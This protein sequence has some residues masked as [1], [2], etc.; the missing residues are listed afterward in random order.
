[1]ENGPP[2]K[3]NPSRAGSRAFCGQRRLNA[4]V[5]QPAHSA[6]F[7]YPS[8][9]V[10]HEETPQ[11]PIRLL[12]GAEGKAPRQ[13]SRLCLV[14]RCGQAIMAS[15]LSLVELFRPAGTIQAR[16]FALPMTLDGWQPI[17][18]APKDGSGVILFEPY[19]GVAC[20]GYW[21]KEDNEWFPSR[22]KQFWKQPTHWQPMPVYVYGEQ[23]R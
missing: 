9:L 20:S 23:E 15:G 3:Q 10:E 22:G 11:T 21:S 18:T 17:E 6:K 1:M 2:R 13:A 16:S 5:R 12:P 4:G 14:D 19:E 8:H 7:T